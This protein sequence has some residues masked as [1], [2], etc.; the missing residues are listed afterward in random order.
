MKIKHLTPT[1]YT[2]R[3]EELSRG[4][5]FRFQKCSTPYML[6]PNITGDEIKAMYKRRHGGV[7]DMLC[8]IE[9]YNENLYI[10]AEDGDGDSLD[11]E[12]YLTGCE[13]E[14]LIAYIRLD[15][16][17][18]LLSHRH[19]IVIPLNAELAVEDLRSPD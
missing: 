10:W 18:I 14:E 9:I 5:V 13:D 8:D 4:T 6:L 3:L 11:E 12:E 16:G 7:E 17:K 2:A 15:D 1:P 19:E